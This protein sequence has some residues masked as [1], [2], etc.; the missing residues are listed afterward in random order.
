M[1]RTFSGFGSTQ[2]FDQGEKDDA[3]NSLRRFCRLLWVADS[4]T[5]RA[6]SATEMYNSQWMHLKISLHS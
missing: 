1:E 3:F 6:P 5:E 2:L 4:F